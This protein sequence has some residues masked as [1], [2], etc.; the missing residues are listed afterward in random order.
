MKTKERKAVHYSYRG[1]KSNSNLIANQNNNN[2]IISK[3][4][5]VEEIPY[6]YYGSQFP[7]NYEE[8]I[9]SLEPNSIS[10]AM[11]SNKFVS[12]EINF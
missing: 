4:I 3:N 10:P 6:S 8:Y 2:N 1:Q 12:I 7:K 11:L 9:A 5:K